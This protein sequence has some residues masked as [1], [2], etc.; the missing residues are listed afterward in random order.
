[1]ML[2]RHVARL[3]WSVTRY[4]VS[5]RSAAILV[6]AAGGLVLVALAVAVQTAVPY[7]LYPFT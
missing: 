2:A 4:S 7:V 1:M 3:L 5:I 6:L